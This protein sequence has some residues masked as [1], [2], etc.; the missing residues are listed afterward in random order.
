MNILEVKN[1]TI[2]YKNLKRAIDSL[3]FPIEEGK[4][5]CI[6]GESG[7]GKSTLGRAIV[8]LLPKGGDIKSGEI[9]YKGADILKLNSKELQ[10]IRGRKIYTVFQ[11]PMAVFNPSLTME[12]Q[13]Y[14]L[15]KSHK[16]V[17]RDFFKLKMTEILDTLGF[18]DSSS[19]LESYPFQLSGGMLQRMAIASGI[20]IEPEII[21]ADEPTTS[22]DAI[23]Q[24]KILLEFLRINREMKTTIILITHDFGVV[25]EV[26]DH[27][28][29]MKD[30]QVVELGNVHKIFDSPKEEYTKSLIENI[31]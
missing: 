26:G 28:V 22:L 1:L 12:E 23:I 31:L 6:V 2:D 29:V 16:D 27:V 15:V 10:T 21:I 13:I 3:S 18:K 11:N 8:N 17:T 9:L 25:A 4:I 30:G 14:S 5:A 19:A 24:K 20:F 7:S